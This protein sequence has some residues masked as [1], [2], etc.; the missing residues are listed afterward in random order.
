MPTVT[1][2]KLWMLK[3]VENVPTDRIIYYFHCKEN[4]NAANSMLSKMCLMPPNPL[5]G[6]QTTR[7]IIAFH[8]A[9][10]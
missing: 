3:S 7:Y 1:Q 2:M 4:M 10:D 8:L 5:I 6:F 9:T